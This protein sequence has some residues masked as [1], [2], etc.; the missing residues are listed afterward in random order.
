MQILTINICF[1]REKCVVYISAE[2]TISKLCSLVSEKFHKPV[3]NL[4]F[5]SRNRPLWSGCFNTI[6]DYD[7]EH[8]SLI[9]V[10]ERMPGGGD[11]RGLYSYF[12]DCL[13][14]DQCSFHKLFNWPNIVKLSKNQE[15]AYNIVCCRF[16]IS[17]EVVRAIEDNSEQSDIRLGDVIHR[18][19]HKGHNITPQDIIKI[20]ETYK[21]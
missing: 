5:F 13:M 2:D 7:I 18:I 20:L 9:F 21:A 3:D 11:P 16:N 12:D 1:G 17:Y 15:N 4:R 8:N 14:K 10:I 19:Y 6:E